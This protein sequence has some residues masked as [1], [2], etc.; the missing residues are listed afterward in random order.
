MSSNNENIEDKKPKVEA[1]EETVEA[2]E[3]L[4]SSESEGEVLD[5]LS[6]EAAKELAEK[7]A[8]MN[9]YV[10]HA[11]S[12]YEYKVK[13]AL[14]EQIR[15]A[16]KEDFFGEILVPCEQVVGIVKGVKKTSSRKF[17]PGYILVQM[18]LNDETWHII[19]DT[20]KITGFVGGMK[21]PPPISPEELI[22]ITTQM[23]E[24]AV[25]PKPKVLFEAGENVRV[26]DGPFMNFTGNVE[27]VKPEKGRL[28]VMVSI[29]GR[30][31]P[32]ELDFVQVE[33]A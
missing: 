14:E 15:L 2:T 27:E 16:G 1:T 5:E 22:K 28:R 3:G 11:Y 24:G 8:R 17:F 10:V 19:N 30:P 32:V 33:K 12:G 31:T 7:N 13:S 4:A 18:D 25:R 23:E 6:E 9:W 29:F 26:I 20:P 21:N